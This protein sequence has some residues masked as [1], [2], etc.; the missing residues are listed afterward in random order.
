M[1]PVLSEPIVMMSGMSLPTFSNDSKRK[2]RQ[3][4]ATFTAAA[5]NHLQVVLAEQ[6]DFF[7]EHG[8]SKYYGDRRHDLNTLA[9]RQI[10]LKRLGKPQHLASEQTSTACIALAM[11]ALRAGFRKTDSEPAWER[12]HNAL[13]ANEVR[14]TDLLHMLA[15]L[16]W[17]VR[18]W[19]PDPLQNQTWDQEDQKLVPLTS[20]RTW[21]PEWGG[22]AL[23]HRASTR[24]TDPVYAGVPVHDSTTL[25]GFGKTT[26]KALDTIPFWV[27]LAH[28]GYLVFPGIKGQVI[29]AHSM[30]DLD[31]PNNIESAPFN[32]L[33]RNGAPKWSRSV[34]YRSGIIAVPLEAEST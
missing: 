22:H 1:Q 13:K 21:M 33:A 30:R 15:N 10:V 12:I 26:P 31:D 24:K 29:E 3:T 25:V 19:N 8:V 7:A 9:E 32:P 5:A 4:I 16:G 11:H 6:R 23:H 18:F 28:G 17:Q 34:R 14:G 2:H 20:G 27:G